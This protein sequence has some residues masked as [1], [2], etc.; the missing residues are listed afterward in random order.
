MTLVK[1][2]L[3]RKCS[4]KGRKLSKPLSSLN[5]KGNIIFAVP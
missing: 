5:K 3:Y 2:P 4:P 1:V